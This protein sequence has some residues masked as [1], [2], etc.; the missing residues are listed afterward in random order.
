MRPWKSMTRRLAPELGKTGPKRRGN[1]DRS[2]NVLGTAWQY[3]VMDWEPVNVEVELRYGFLM[4]T[5]LAW[6]VDILRSPLRDEILAISDYD[7]FPRDFLEVQRFRVD[8]GLS[9]N[10]RPVPH[11]LS[12]YGIEG[13]EFAEALDLALRVASRELEDWRS[14]H[15]RAN[16][17][18]VGLK[19]ERLGFESLFEREEQLRLEDFS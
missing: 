16:V 5:D 3:R 7:R 12:R 10:L 13:R 6:A 15:N 19:C 11:V 1:R 14:T 9:L 4:T 8:A 18:S 17:H 2:Q